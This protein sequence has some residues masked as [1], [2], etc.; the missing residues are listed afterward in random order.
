VTSRRS[1]FELEALEPRVL[2]SG[3]PLPASPT[4]VDG[5]PSPEISSLL[6]DEAQSTPFAEPGPSLFDGSEFEDLADDFDAQIGV[7]SEQDSAK[8]RKAAE[9]VENEGTV[10]LTPD[11][12]SI[13]MAMA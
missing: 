10:G 11:P 1:Q 8:D 9:V 12:R 5:L 3:T 7:Q 2:L 6:S 13:S 4:A